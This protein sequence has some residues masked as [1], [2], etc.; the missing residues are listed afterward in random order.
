MQDILDKIYRKLHHFF[1]LRVDSRGKSLWLFSSYRFYRL[2]KNRDCQ[3]SKTG[4]AYLTQKPNRGAGIGHQ[5]GNWLSGFCVAKKLNIPYVYS[6]FP[7]VSMRESDAWDT[8]LGFGENLPKEKDL[9]AKGFRVRK[10][11]YV[12][13]NNQE[14]VNLLNEIIQTHV[15]HGKKVIFHLELDQFY[16]NLQ[17]SLPELQELFYSAESRK[18]DQLVYEKDCINIAVHIRRGD[19]V[20]GQENNDPS[21]TKRWLD[22]AYYLELLKVIEGMIPEEKKYRIYIFSQGTEEDFK[23]FSEIKN[24]EYCFQMP[25]ME[26]F[27]HMIMADILII[28]KSSFSYKPAL[29]SKGLKICPEHFWHGYPQNDMWIKVDEEKGLSQQQQEVI[30]EFANGC[31]KED[32]LSV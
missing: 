31:I 14:E 8:F 21:L 32:K 18:K 10:L 24:I 25:A 17:E 1:W 20:K 22:N 30:R 28:S 12:D 15:K 16:E 19:I 2:H 11:P 26:S 27:L 4:E 29:L 3:S 7:N 9:K 6:E 23:E 13:V 5:L